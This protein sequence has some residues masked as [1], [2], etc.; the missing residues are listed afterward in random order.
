MNFK[1]HPY[2]VGLNGVVGKTNNEMNKFVVCLWKTSQDRG[3]ILP[4]RKQL[5][6]LRSTR[7]R[8]LLHQDEKEKI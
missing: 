6:G 2:E 5:I 7:R 4:L 1:E 8:K 3:E